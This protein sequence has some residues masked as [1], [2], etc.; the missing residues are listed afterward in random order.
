MGLFSRKPRNEAVVDPAAGPTNGRHDP[1]QR[2]KP[3]N[4]ALFDKESGH[5]NRRLSFGQW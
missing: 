5:L 1:H 2:E 3:T 4:R